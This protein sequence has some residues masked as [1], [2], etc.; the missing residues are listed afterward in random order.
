MIKPSMVV[1]QV[2]QLMTQRGLWMVLLCLLGTTVGAQGWQKTFGGNKEDQGRIV[3][4]TIDHGFLVL[5]FSES[6]EGVNSNDIDIYVIRTDVDGTVL[7]TKVY[8][9]GFAEQPF[10]VLELEDGSYL[11]LGSIR[12]T[13]TSNRQIYLLNID[14]RGNKNWSKVIASDTDDTGISFVPSIDGNGYT[15]LGTTFNPASGTGDDMLLLSIDKE[16]EEKWRKVFGTDKKDEPY[17]IVAV[18]DGYIFTGDSPVAG[19]TL[20]NIVFRKVDVDGNI[21]WTK[22]FGKANQ[23]ESGQDLILS[24][25]GNLLITGTQGFKE[26]LVGKFDLNGDSIWV[27]RQT[28][29]PGDNV[30]KNIAEL[31]NGDIVIAGFASEG[32]GGNNYDIVFAR[33]NSE[34]NLIRSALIGEGT[35]LDFGESIEITH[36]EG[37]IITGYNG[38]E[39]NF[40]NDLI[41]F[42]LDG[43]G[44]VVTNQIS[45]KVY[46]SIAGCDGLDTMDIGLENWIVVAESADETYFSTTDATGFYSAMVDTGTYTIKV[47]PPN[48]LW[49]ICEPEIYIVALNEFYDTTD[50]NFGVTAG[51]DCPAMQVDVTT[52]Y[53]VNCQ[54]ATYSISYCNLGPVVGEAAY[55]EVVLDEELTYISSSISPSSQNGAVL[56]FQ[57]GDVASMAC[58][59]FT[60]T[61][62]MACEGVVNGQATWVSAHI[63]PDTIC[64]GVE[65]WSGASVKVSGNCDRAT[66]TLNFNIRNIGTANMTRELNYFVVEDDLMFRTGTFNLPKEANLPVSIQTQQGATYRLIAEQEEGHPG[67]SYPTVAI[68]GCV[69]DGAP[70]T[71]GMVTQFTEDEADAFQAVDVQEA[72]TIGSGVLMRGYP[73]GYQDFIIDQNTEIEYTIIFENTGSDIIDR[74]VIRDTLSRF[75]DASSIVLGASSH[76]Y[77]FQIYDNGILKITFDEIQLQPGGS[78]EEANSFGY[79][80][81]RIA[82]KPI[83]SVGIVI[84][85]GA[86]VYFDYAAPQPTNVVSHTV[87]C[88]DLLNAGCIISDAPEPGNPTSVTIK[89]S[90]NPFFEST[91]FEISG[92]IFDTVMFS[93][94]DVS[95]KLIRTDRFRGNNYDFYRKSLP[96]GMY[97]Y[98]M[99]AEGQVFATGKIIMR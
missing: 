76:P 74:V 33:F 49:D 14:K 97:V 72:L 73:K 68:E 83:N 63:Y 29:A 38:K 89:V 96:A 47:L 16:N 23:I 1:P 17:G 51:A 86:T 80:Q 82:Q 94:Y 26:I 53:I 30:G 28:I 90:P 11:I 91:S 62:Q 52:P 7:W 19:G 60:I 67:Q 92:T 43:T 21:L 55:I 64:E 32:N 59:E 36:D 71:T 84:E 45:G 77:E 27:Q 70:Y 20:N 37:F 93:L 5:G 98:R 8:D 78:T 31:P 58:G 95:G 46:H 9:E 41:L 13:F 99:E 12:P 85:N 56:Q 69:T 3:K 10:D 40:F 61:A 66:G 4:E 75:L 81:F 88:T 18:A 87:G 35:N 22:P 39:N 48:H 24:R 54:N 34:G 57:L 42:R 65:N 6:F 25:D 2:L 79:V 50:I 15:I 44:N